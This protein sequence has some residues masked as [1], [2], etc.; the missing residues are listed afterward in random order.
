MAQLQQFILNHWM[1]WVALIVIVVFILINEVI[2]NK[3]K[4]KE[5]SPSAAVNMINSQDAVVIDLRDAEAYKTGH[6]VNSIRA[7][8]EDFSQQKMSKY[9][10]KPLILVCPRGVQSSSLANKLR[11][12]GYSNPMVLSGGISAW[13]AANLPLVKKTKG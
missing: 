11:I 8:A 7:T 6:I 10:D 4:A 12:Q 13:S 3:K 2:S 1:L 5:L 9:K